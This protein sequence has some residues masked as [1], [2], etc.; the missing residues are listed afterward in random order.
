MIF[1]VQSLQLLGY[2]FE[3]T[4][5][6]A[7][8]LTA[9]IIFSKKSKYLA[10]TFMAFGNLFIGLYV[11]FILVY[12]I[13]GKT[14]AIQ[15]FLPIAMTCILIGTLMLF[16]SMLCIIKS[17]KWFDDWYHWVPYVLIVIAYAIYILTNKNFITILD[18]EVVNTQIDLIPLGILV[19]LLLFFLGASEYVV[20]FFGIKKTEGD[21]RKKMNLFSTGIIFGIIAILINV[22]SQIMAEGTLGEILD[23]IFFGTLA[24]CV[25]LLSIALGKK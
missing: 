8:I 11:A 19:V 1:Q 18:T 14:W 25:V 24:I 9:L 21:S 10:N 2:I 16:F 5:I 12:D 15:T 13:I 6:V 7:G 20:I 17:D 23:V 3:I 22:V 4:A